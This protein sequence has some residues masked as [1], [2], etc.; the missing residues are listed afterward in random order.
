MAL[1]LLLAACG[2]DGEDAAATS[3]VATTTAPTTTEPVPVTGPGAAFCELARGYSERLAKLIPSLG[4]PG[5]LRQLLADSGPII[6]QAEAAAPP[7]IKPDVTLLANSSRELLV[8]LERVDFDF[9]KVPPA[10]VSRIQTPEVQAAGQRL[11]AYTR[12]VCRVG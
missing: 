7:D 2:G 3:T 4:D 10:E 1:V 5:T 12:D 6:Q 8:L 11:A 9:T